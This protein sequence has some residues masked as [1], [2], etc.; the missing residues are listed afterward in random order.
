MRHRHTVHVRGEVRRQEGVR[1]GR[2]RDHSAHPAAGEGQR[3]RRN[4]R[5]HQGEDGGRG[6]PGKGGRHRKRV[7]G[8][9]AALR[10]HAAVRGGRAG[11][12]LGAGRFGPAQQSRREGGAVVGRGQMGRRGHVLGGR[13]R[14]GLQLADTPGQ[15][16]LARGSPRP[17]RPRG[18]TRVRARRRRGTRRLRTHAAGRP[19]RTHRR[20]RPHGGDEDVRRAR[21]GAVVRRGLLRQGE[22]VHRP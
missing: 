7:D 16:R 12:V 18:E 4:H 2:V 6:H 20:G 1:R 9:R 14:P 11:S 22:A 3:V 5:G 17:D 19:V 8:V 10:E 13:L 21:P 15:A